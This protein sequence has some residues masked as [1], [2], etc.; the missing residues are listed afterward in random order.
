MA[1]NHE[2]NVKVENGDVAAGE[3]SSATTSSNGPVKSAY[4]KY[5]EQFE[6]QMKD[7]NFFKNK[8]KGGSFKKGRSEGGQEAQGRRDSKCHSARA[9]GGGGF[10]WGRR[11]GVG[12]KR[13]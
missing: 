13:R 3:N 2:E 6:K 8:K 7:P 5:V 9:G 10:C 4:D 11:R 12:G 1:D